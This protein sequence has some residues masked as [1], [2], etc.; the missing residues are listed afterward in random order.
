MDIYRYLNISI[1]S[2]CFNSQMLAYLHRQNELEG[3]LFPPAFAYRDIF[4]HALTAFAR[5]KAADANSAKDQLS[6]RP[7]VPGLPGMP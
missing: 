7:D 5:Q 2:K 6:F 1:I 3:G 4:G